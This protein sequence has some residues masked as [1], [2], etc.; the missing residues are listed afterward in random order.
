MKLRIGLFCLLG[1]LCFTTSALGT[2][3]IGW[4][5]L[6]GV[7]LTA[8][9]VP[10]VRYGAHWFTARFTSVA[11]ALIVIG[12]VCTISEAALFYPQ[13][14]A[15]LMQAAVGGSILY[16]AVAFVLVGLAQLLKLQTETEFAVEH[17]P[18]RSTIPMVLVIAASYVVYYMVFGGIAFQ[19][20]TKQ[21]YPHAVQ[22][23]AAL[24]NWFWLHQLGRGLLM[25]LAVLPIIYTLRLPRWQAAVVV[26]LL[27][28][29]AGG[30]ASLL[31]PNTMMVA[32]QRYAH[33]VEIFTQN[34]SLG[35]TATLLLRRKESAVGVHAH[36]LP[37]A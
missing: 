4:G 34:F 9:L 30:G 31:V 36:P 11:L 20:F 8:S 2:G 18:L 35:M 16:L 25:T 28:W 29:I 7:I 10:I 21:Y 17:R 27:V 32:P 23:V 22:D 1:G 33:I 19:F 13:T 26:G 14:K 37:A 24:G 6:A 3:H 5:Y 15:M 12:I